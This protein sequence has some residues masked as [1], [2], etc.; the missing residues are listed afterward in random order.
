ME[1]LIRLVRQSQQKRAAS[2]VGGLIG[3]LVGD[4]VGVPYE[5]RDAD[6]LPPL[7]QID[8]VPPAGFRRTYPDVP[9]ATYSDDG[10]QALCLLASLLDNDALVLD[11]FADRLVRWYEHGYMAVDSI[12]FDCG[13]QT[14]DAIERIRAGKLPQQSGGTGEMENGNGSLSRVLPLALWHQ[15]S[16]VSLVED[17]HRQSLPTHAHPRSQVSCAYYCL[18]ARGY[19][20]T[21]CD[22]WE[23]ALEALGTVYSSWEGV[24]SQA[25]FEAELVRLIDYGRHETPRGTGYVLDT[26]WSARL[27]MEENTFKGVVQKA[28]SLGND[29]D[30]TACVAAGLAGIRFGLAG[31]P[32]R[33]LRQ[34]RGLELVEPLGVALLDHSNKHN[35]TAALPPSDEQL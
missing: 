6:T 32:D 30:T 14:S 7:R 27:A 26:I 8:M 25:V 1:A 10:A 20:N 2:I 24:I 33:W 35:V 9:L 18:V 17:A 22:P 23:A 29:T 11:D 31:I 5:F 15:G 12:V 34:L 19:L 13:V 3:L 28:I 16:D 21:V 4:A